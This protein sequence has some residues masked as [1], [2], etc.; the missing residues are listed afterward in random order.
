MSKTLNYNRS[1]IRRHAKREII[2]ETKRNI[3]KQIL[4]ENYDKAIN[5][6]MIF[7]IASKEDLRNI[8]KI[9]ENN[10]AEL[11][12]IDKAFR[13]AII[14]DQFTN[15]SRKV[16]N[17]LR[18]HK[19]VNRKGVLKE[20]WAD[21]GIDMFFGF[22]P[23]IADFPA[24]VALTGGT[25]MGVGRAIAFA[26]MLYYGG[27]LNVALKSDNT[28]DA[29]IHGMSLFLSLIAAFPAVGAALAGYGRTVLNLFKRIAAPIW[30]IF[31]FPLKTIFTGGA[32]IKAAAA[33]KAFEKG[34]EIASKHSGLSD[35]AL[36]F[37]A[38]AGE[39]VIKNGGDLKVLSEIAKKGG[40][41]V[42]EFEKFAPALKSALESIPMAGSKMAGLVDDILK[43]LKP[44]MEAVGPAA[45]GLSEVAEVT[46]KSNL[47]KEQVGVLTARAAAAME[48][49]GVKATQEAVELM[50]RESDEFAAAAK[51]LGFI[52]DAFKTLAKTGDNIT[53]SS[54]AMGQ[55]SK[56]FPKMVQGFDEIVAIGIG[57]TG[58]KLGPEAL[59]STM[60][61]IRELA[62]DGVE[63]FG[64]YVATH[65]PEITKT[66]LAQ[67]YSSVYRSLFQ[68]M[69][70]ISRIAGVTMKESIQAIPQA[71]R[72][73]GK[74]VIDDI[75]MEGG[76]LIAKGAS[77]ADKVI[78]PKMMQVPPLSKMIPNIMGT[79]KTAI[80]QNAPKV[81]Q[82][83]AQTQVQAG[84][85]VTQAAIEGGEEVT[86][87]SLKAGSE[88]VEEVSQEL[89]KQ[90]DELLTPAAANS[91]EQQVAK[92]FESLEIILSPSKWIKFGEK[93]YYDVIA[94]SF[95]SF[96]DPAV[97][98]R[99]ST[100]INEAIRL[101]EKRDR[102]QKRIKKHTSLK[103]LY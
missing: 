80:N 77:G 54:K 45:K 27:K 39:Q 23:M 89:M 7:D 15:T 64:T 20:S 88:T 70:D 47:A 34:I 26:G 18:E 91:I 37:F 78:T 38:E 19:V 98:Q 36:K 4:L 66:A 25:S 63:G 96:I 101:L 48:P 49:A 13:A 97:T 85:K 35:D 11:I 74:F 86:K 62:V 87:A 12:A 40:K 99:K 59:E 52:D 5:A 53:V 102:R 10:K 73:M 90:T 75:V 72:S 17:I 68:G 60:K 41:Y 29:F 46:A 65:G 61:S 92:Q 6:S 71:S 9:V 79:M 21:F 83:M 43:T 58:K 93:F 84:A 51:Q 100:G 22:A 95:R 57:E 2:K 103:I 16:N 44:A 82:R 30:K 50:A 1:L 69:D 33:K 55:A 14:N 32:N 28:F 8:I 42:V 67:G 56:A 3:A 81:A 94:G 31:S 24:V 76:Q